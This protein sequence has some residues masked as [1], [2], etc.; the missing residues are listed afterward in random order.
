MS[1]AVTQHFGPLWLECG[2]KKRYSSRMWADAMARM[3]ERSETWDGYPLRSF[4]CSYCSTWHLAHPPSPASLANR[5]ADVRVIKCGGC[6]KPVTPRAHVVRDDG[7]I[8]WARDSDPTRCAAC[9]PS[10]VA[11]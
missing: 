4:L 8:D 11:S 5:N 7:S 10:E 3:I 1:A 6:G 2:S 9:Q